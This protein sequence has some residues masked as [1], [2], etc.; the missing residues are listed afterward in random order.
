[1]SRGPVVHPTQ[2]TQ[3]GRRKFIHSAEFGLQAQKKISRP[4]F[5]VPGMCQLRQ[6]VP[7]PNGFEDILAAS[8]GDSRKLFSRRSK[9]NRTLEEVQPSHLTTLNTIEKKLFAP[10]IERQI[11]STILFVEPIFLKRYDLCVRVWRR[12]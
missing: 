3:E 7:N 4:G 9:N 8:V 5:R 11:H 2:M 12:V 10:S 6:R 1:M